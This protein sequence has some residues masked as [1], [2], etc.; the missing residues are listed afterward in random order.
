MKK[1][2]LINSIALDYNLFISSEFDADDYIGARQIAVDGSSVLFVQAKG[3]FTKEV[4][5]SSKEQG[6]VGEDLRVTLMADVDTTLKVITFDD[7]T[8][9]NYYYDHTV[10]PM[11]FTPI[12]EGACWYIATINML[13]A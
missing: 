12:F 6:W 11:S 10:V 2:K 4:V 8:T 9:G 13:K 7:D 3:A 1:V 5:I